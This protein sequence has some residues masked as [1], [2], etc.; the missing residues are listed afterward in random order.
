MDFLIRPVPH[1]AY[2]PV[3]A[4]AISCTFDTDGFTLMNAVLI[5][6]GLDRE[7][8]RKCAY[9]HAGEKFRVISH[10][11]EKPF[12]ITTTKTERWDS[13][14]TATELIIEAADAERCESL[15]MTH[16]AF[17]LREFPSTAFKQC[18]DSIR[19]IGVQEHIKRVIVDVDARY[20]NDAIH[21]SQQADLPSSVL[22]DWS[23][24]I[25]PSYH[26]VLGL[27]TPAKQLIQ[28]YKPKPSEISAPQR[29]R[30]EAMDSRVLGLDCSDFDREE[31]M[32][33]VEGAVNALLVVC[34]AGQ[35]GAEMTNFAAEYARSLKIPVHVLMSS[36]LDWEGRKRGATALGLIENLGMIGAEIRIVA[37]EKF[38][39]ASSWQEAFDRIDTAMLIEID[40]WIGE[41]R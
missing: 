1:A 35:S 5:Q 6:H 15:C 7:Y 41:Q 4:D 33:L 29:V 21:L 9:M 10:G 8:F 28:R 2:E 14:P 39:D 34:G 27:G 19:N 3:K 12:V 25:S 13:E 22:D 40:R 36:P 11:D 24:T 16:F 26:L 18:I 32:A 20:Y 38:D 23:S 30:I 17:I 37:G 31:L